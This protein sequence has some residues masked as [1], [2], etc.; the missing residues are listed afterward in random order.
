MKTTSQTQELKDIDL[1]KK[2]STR[3]TYVLRQA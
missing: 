2:K 3:E 1:Y